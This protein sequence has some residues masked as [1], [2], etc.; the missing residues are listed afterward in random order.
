M[1]SLVESFQFSQLQF[2]LA[3]GSLSDSPSDCLTGIL[4]VPFGV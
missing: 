2:L 1:T 4:F 3:S